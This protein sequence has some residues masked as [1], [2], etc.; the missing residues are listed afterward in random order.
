MWG[1]NV[2]VWVQGSMCVCVSVP[3]GACIYVYVR[4]IMLVCFIDLTL[5]FTQDITQRLRKFYIPLNLE[6][7]FVQCVLKLPIQT[8]HRFVNRISIVCLIDDRLIFDFC[9]LLLPHACCF[10]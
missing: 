7:T 9:P 4:I 3:V 6:Y 2:Y 1:R 5:Q 8:V 10:C